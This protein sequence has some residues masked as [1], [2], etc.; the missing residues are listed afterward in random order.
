M[1]QKKGR[2]FS[3]L[4]AQAARPCH[5]TAAVSTATFHTFVNNHAVCA[6]ANAAYAATENWVCDAS[7]DFLH[8]TFLMGVF[9]HTIVYRKSN[10]VPRQK[11]LRHCFAP[12]FSPVPG[13]T[14]HPITCPLGQKQ[15]K[16]YSFLFAQAARP[17]HRSAAVFT[18]TF[19]PFV[20]NKTVCAFANA[21][22]AA[23]ENWVYHA[24]LDF[25]NATFLMRNPFLQL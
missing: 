5:R 20:N 15:G 1:R 8:A 10:W 7:L 18:E 17:C 6:S 19:N 22:Y 25:L 3:L 12:G 11:T 2:I 9:L 13:S 23:T 24:S 4:F 14:H 16:I 21:T